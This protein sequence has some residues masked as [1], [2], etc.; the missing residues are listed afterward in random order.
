MSEATVQ[1]K[2]KRS[3]WAWLLWWR[4]DPSDLDEQVTHYKSLSFY[5]SARGQSAI[6]LL[7]S[8]VLT[9][10][11]EA[12]SKSVNQSAFVDAAVFLILA[13]F[14][15]LGHRWAL[16][17]AMVAWT[18]EKGFYIFAAIGAAQT[19][20]TQNSGLGTGIVIQ[21]FWWCIYMHVFYL[22]FRVEREKRRRAAAAV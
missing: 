18:L 10:V 22:A 2:K 3:S 9:V 17:T 20:A 7:L 11:L 6:C 16:M 21:L 19:A 13:L 4:I 5:K 15:F 8:V 12:M 1:A 14:V